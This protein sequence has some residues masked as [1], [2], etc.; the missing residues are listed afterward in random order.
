MQGSIAMSA[1]ADVVLQ[2]FRAV[3]ERDT[4]KLL[5]LYHP[6]IELHEASSLPFGGSYVGFDA[7]L[8]HARARQ[9]TW[10]GLQD[11]DERRMEPRIVAAARDETVV[12]WRQR[13]SISSGERLDSPVLALYR[14]RGGKLAWAQMFRFDTAA[15]ANFLRR[16]TGARR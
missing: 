16:A 6:Q 15:V 11:D 3:E 12:L 7:V 8:E 10:D 13:A 1:R 2:L 4:T 9:E 5:S 14:F